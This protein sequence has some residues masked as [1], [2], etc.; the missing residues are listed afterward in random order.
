MSTGS[1]CREQDAQAER[2]DLAPMATSGPSAEIKPWPP[3]YA[4]RPLPW[5]GLTR[6]WKGLLTFLAARKLD[7]AGQL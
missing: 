3:A 6:I 4:P 5:E 2:I 1:S 7:F